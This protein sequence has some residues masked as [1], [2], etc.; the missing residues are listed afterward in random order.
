[1]NGVAYE[2]LSVRTIRSVR[3]VTLLGVILSVLGA[4][5]LA[6]LMKEVDSTAMTS[7]DYLVLAARLNIA[8]PVVVLMVA[9]TIGGSDISRGLVVVPILRDRG[10]SGVWRSR[11]CLAAALGAGT[12]LVMAGLSYL[13]VGLAVGFASPSGLA[14]VLG[15]TVAQGVGWASLGLGLGFLLRGVVGVVAIPLVL[16]YAVEPVIRSMAAMGPL[17]DVAATI[18]PFAAATSLVRSPE[19]F[20]AAFDVTG[21]APW[22]QSALTFLVPAALVAVAGW[23]RFRRADLSPRAVG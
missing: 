13:A 1:M 7:T 2:W 17:G 8:L 9:G 4:A 14:S 10:R 20:S 3:I 21:V 16:A 12:A 6:L 5:G 22:A 11:W 23:L 15:G 19:A 18:A